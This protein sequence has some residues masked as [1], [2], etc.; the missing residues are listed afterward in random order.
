MLHHAE[1]DV[2][3]SYPK[4]SSSHF[5]CRLLL[6]VDKNKKT[7]KRLKIFFLTFLILLSHNTKCYH[8]MTYGSGWAH[9]RLTWPNRG[10]AT[11]EH[12]KWRHARNLVHSIGKP[13]PLTAAALTNQTYPAGSPCASP[14]RFSHS[15]PARC[16]SSPPPQGKASFTRPTK[17][18]LIWRAWTA[19]QFCF[20]RLWR[21]GSSALW[22][23]TWSPDWPKRPRKRSLG[24]CISST[25]E[26]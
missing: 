12:Y 6:C 20:W 17:T 11:Q 10:V 19:R 26:K 8:I 18:H 24:R 13:Y 16:C 21:Q 2:T 7:C 22:V 15:S 23:W 14:T 4:I 9:H 1:V 5:C 25:G 3:K